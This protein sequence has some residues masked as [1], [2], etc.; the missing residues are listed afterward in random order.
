[1]TSN[2]IIGKSRMNNQERNAILECLPIEGQ[3][4]EIGTY[5]G[6][7]AAYWASFRPDLHIVSI[8][9]FEDG[10]M[11]EAGDPEIWRANARENQA[12]YEGA[13]PDF[14]RMYGGD[15]FNVIFIDGSHNFKWCSIDLFISDVLLE[16]GGMIMVHDYCDGKKCMGIKAAVAEFCSERKYHIAQHFHRTVTIRRDRK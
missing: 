15:K 8:D 11:A 6:A 5:H 13:S 4:L 16:E 10:H 7:S 1:M 2:K 12:L 3:M 14:L 9:P